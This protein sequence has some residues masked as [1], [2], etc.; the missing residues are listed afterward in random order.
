MSEEEAM[1]WAY[2]ESLRD[3]QAAPP[4]VQARADVAD[5]DCGKS[6]DQRG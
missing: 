3:H 1:Q 2:L 6:E 5:E 4:T